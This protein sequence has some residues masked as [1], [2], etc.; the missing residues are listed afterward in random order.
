VVFDSKENDPFAAMV[1]EKVKAGI[2]SSGSIGFKPNAVEF[3]EDSK[4]PTRLIHRKWEL[5]E[6]S[7]CN[8]PSNFNAL[9]IREAEPGDIKMQDKD[10]T[11][12]VE[13]IQKLVAKIDALD[14]EIKAV[15]ARKQSYVDALMRDHD[16][17]SQV[18]KDESVDEDTVDRLFVASETSA[19][20]EGKPGMFGL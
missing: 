9:A 17:T 10:K 8:V 3:V 5:L 16:E 2:I 7:I 6:F 13:A 4:D 14:A 20:A 1:G 18:E 19:P 11:E 15:Q 12:I